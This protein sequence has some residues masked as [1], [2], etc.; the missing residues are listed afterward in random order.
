[1][2]SLLSLF[3]KDMIC[4]RNA[5]RGPTGRSVHRIFSATI[6]CYDKS[7]D[8]S[9]LMLLK[10]GSCLPGN[11]SINRSNFFV[12]AGSLDG[13]GSAS[14]TFIPP[15]LILSVRRSQPSQTAS[16]MCGRSS[17]GIFGDVSF[18]MNRA[19]RKVMADDSLVPISVFPSHPRLTISGCLAA[20]SSNL[21]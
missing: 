21:A 5:I 2:M 11:Q 18:E 16:K 20:A 4:A 13:G 8:R 15:T 6:F 3:G 7:A 9:R 12:V 1:M 19:S 10:E 14:F 17:V